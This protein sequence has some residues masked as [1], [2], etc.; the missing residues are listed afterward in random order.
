MSAPFADPLKGLKAA[1][2]ARRHQ[3]EPVVS[4]ADWQGPLA[5]MVEM[6]Q[7]RR[8]DLKAVSMVDLVT[9]CLDS[10]SS[11]DRVEDKAEQLVLAADLTLMKSR[12]LLGAEDEREDEEEALRQQALKLDRIRRIAALLMGGDQLG[13]E[14]WPRGAPEINV[15]RTVAGAD[16]L[17]IVDVIQAYA[18]LRLR[19]EADAP[20]EVRRILAMTLAEALAK[21]G[22]RLE[23]LDGWT[24]LFAWAGQGARPKDASARS[25]AAASFVAALEMAKQ[26]DVQLRQDEAFGDVKV[27]KGRSA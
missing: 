3:E 16:D 26:G 15:D 20:M 27:A 9:A 24:E 2:P 13:R 22:A 5:L 25:Q 19:D 4:T 6:A 1:E 11:F 23:E 7:R 12:L 18:R 14:I 17:S 21:L 8:I 10:L